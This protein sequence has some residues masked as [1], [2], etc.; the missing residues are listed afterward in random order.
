[1]SFLSGNG[2]D[3]LFL[4]FCVFQ[5]KW[6]KWDHVL[7]CLAS[8]HSTYCTGIMQRSFAHNHETSNRIKGVKN[9][10]KQN[11]TKKKE[12]R[13][14]LEMS[15]SELNLGP[16]CSVNSDLKGTMPTFLTMRSMAASVSWSLLRSISISISPEKFH[17]ENYW[18]WN[19]AFS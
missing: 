18:V 6:N 8:A 16:T 3:T 15:E 17:L 10:I 13:N 2:I 12:K 5:L 14:S 1:M 19:N 9:K 7:R 11:R 4:C